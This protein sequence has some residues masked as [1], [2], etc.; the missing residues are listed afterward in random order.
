MWHPI[1]II[2]QINERLSDQNKS[3]MGKRRSKNK[4][5]ATHNGSLLFYSDSWTYRT[6]RLSPPDPPSV[7]QAPPPCPIYSP[8]GFMPNGYAPN[9]RPVYRQFLPSKYINYCAINR[10]LRSLGFCVTITFSFVLWE[11]NF[12][13]W[14]WIKFY[15]RLFLVVP[16]E[17]RGYS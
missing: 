1:Y 14:K 17:S 2:V 13:P 5:H 9:F 12:V 4:N 15:S 10:S 7:R 16:W 6:L 8:H 11:M 3:H